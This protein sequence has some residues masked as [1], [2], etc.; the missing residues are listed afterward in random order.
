[1]SLFLLYLRLFGKNLRARYLNFF[2]IAVSFV[3]YTATTFAFGY[4][5]VRRLSETWLES[6]QSDRCLEDTV[7]LYYIQG[8][9]CLVSD[10]YISFLPVPL[11]WRLQMPLGKRIGVLAIF[12]T[13]VL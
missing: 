1:L 3:V 2:G 12:A 7:P 4:L 9:L 13:S 8:I 6:Q 10:L 5:C 11:V